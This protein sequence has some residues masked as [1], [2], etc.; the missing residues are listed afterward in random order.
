METKIKYDKVSWKKVEH[1]ADRIFSLFMEG[2]EVSFARKAWSKLSQAGLTK[3]RN[4]FDETIVFLR[5][6]ALVELYLGYCRIAHEEDHDSEYYDWIDHLDLEADRIH[7]VYDAIFPN[8]LEKD[9]IEVHDKIGALSSYFH[10]EV[11]NCLM[12][13]FG[14]ETGLF[15]ALWKSTHDRGEETDYEILNNPSI[16]KLQVYEWIDRGCEF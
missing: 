12:K 11:F 8:E 15:L 14:T 6:I 2:K 1:A 9:D 7:P 5:F 4:E 3:C 10:K 16:D 13:G